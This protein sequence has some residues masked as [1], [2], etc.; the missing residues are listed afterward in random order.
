MTEHVPL[1][2]SWTCGGCGAPWPCPT[3]RRQLLAEYDET[4]VSLSL[5]MA[6]YRSAAAPDLPETPTEA[7]HERFIGWIPGPG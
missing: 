1:R 3:R 5:L 6:G 4:P 2:P 7:L